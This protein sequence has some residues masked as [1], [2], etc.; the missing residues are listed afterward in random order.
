MEKL[1]LRLSTIA[2]LV[3]DGASVCDVGTDHGFLPIFLKSSGK[4]KGV[5]AT[6]INV[7]PL[8]KAEENIKKSGVKGISLRLCDGVADIKKGEAD[9]VII[10]GIGGEVISGILERGSEIVKDN[11]VIL[12]LQPT[13]SPEFLRRYLMDNGFEILKEIPIEEN[14]KLYSVMKCVYEGKTQKCP[15]WFY[16]SGLVDP[17]NEIGKKYIEKQ[18]K[19]ALKCMKALEMIASRQKEYN[20]YKE[21]YEGLWRLTADS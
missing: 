16:Y 20:F 10:A 13:T 9:T 12:I 2:G 11:G 7:L 5:I 6:D 19:R 1:S 17:K 3:R 15:E 21:I 18:A 14:D 8:K 4:A